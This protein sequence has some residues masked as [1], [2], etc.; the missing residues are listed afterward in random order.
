MRVV[1]LCICSVLLIASSTIAQNN[2]ITETEFHGF[3]KASR[4]ITGDVAYRNRQSFEIANQIAGPWR[5]DGSSV[6]EAIPPDRFYTTY[7]S[8]QP[9]PSIY[10]GNNFYSKQHD[11]SWKLEVS[12]HRAIVP[13]PAVIHGFDPP[14]IEVELQRDGNK[15]IVTVISK[16]EAS[17]G[18]DKK[19]WRTYIY[20]FDD[21][22]VLVEKTSIGHTGNNWV[23]YT[24]RFEYDPTINIV[25]PLIDRL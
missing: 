3:L 17:A 18:E 13:S 12:E 21:R 1:W 10:I 23:K 5:A 24:D 20:R 9:S 2:A 19:K 4:A 22:G 8:G 11:G 7:S 14:R 25:A 6:S 15:A 16:P